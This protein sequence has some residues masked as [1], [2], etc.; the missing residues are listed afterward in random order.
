MSPTRTTLVVDL[1]RLLADRASDLHHAEVQVDRLLESLFPGWRPRFPMRLGWRFTGPD[2]LDVYGVAESASARGA[3]S[4]A[5]F[6]SVTL[7]DHSALA[8]TR[9]NCG[10]REVIT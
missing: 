7:H 3:L 6:A 2:T 9:C 8:S 1:A 10:S 5:G 4:L